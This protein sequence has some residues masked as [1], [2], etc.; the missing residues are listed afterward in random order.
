MFLNSRV[1]VTVTL[2]CHENN[3]FFITY[4]HASCNTI[5]RI[6]SYVR[7]YTE[8][9]T[10]DPSVTFLASEQKIF[11]DCGLSISHNHHYL[12]KLVIYFEFLS[13]T[14]LQIGTHLQYNCVPICNKLL[15]IG[16]HL[17]CTC[18]PICN[19]LLQIGTH[20][21]CNCVPICNKL[22]QI[23]THLQCTCVPICNKLLQI[24]T[25]LQCICVPISNKILYF[26][27]YTSNTG[28]HRVT[29][30]ASKQQISGE[31]GL[32]LSHNSYHL[33]DLVQVV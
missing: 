4:W 17:Q 7:W 6:V 25:H 13:N 12:I 9:N 24:G 23:G 27:W 33:I 20:L 11:G 14:L 28:D 5:L 10:S 3:I 8:N 30:F 22:L 31:C 26:R 18:V 19:K 32:W 15:Q 29:L 1:R 2:I 21:Q 16:T